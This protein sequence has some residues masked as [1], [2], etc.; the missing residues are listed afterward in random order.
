MDRASPV[1]DI[2]PDLAASPPTATEPLRPVIRWSLAAL[3]LLAL[4]IGLGAIYARAHALRR[5]AR[6]GP[7]RPV[8]TA[9]NWWIVALSLW[10]ATGL[11][12]LLAGTEKPAAVYFHH[13][14]FWTKMAL[15]AAL[16]VIEVWPMTI[17]IQWGIWIGRG[18]R[19]HTTAAAALAATSYVQ[20]G[21]LILILLAATALAR[22]FG[23]PT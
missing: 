20:A 13:P 8:F 23:T 3:H 21:L 12:R 19:I 9:D 2:S 18:R 15:A 11:A 17:L 16:Y 6:G 5:L 22:G 1:P 7:L 4:G 14:L 10:L